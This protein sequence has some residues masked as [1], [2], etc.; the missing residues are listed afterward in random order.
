VTSF[1]PV[2]ARRKATVTPAA[3]SG[4]ARPGPQ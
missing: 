4:G 1:V 3:A 2:A